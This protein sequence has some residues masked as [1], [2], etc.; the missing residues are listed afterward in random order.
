MTYSKHNIDSIQFQING[1]GIVYTITVID[2]KPKIIWGDDDKK[3]ATFYTFK[4][5]LDNLEN[6]WVPIV[7]SQAQSYDIF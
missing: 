2:N 3:V 1:K 5:I 7:S 6:V 4:N